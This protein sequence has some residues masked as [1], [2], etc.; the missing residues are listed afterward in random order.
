MTDL[1]EVFTIRHEPMPDAWGKY[2]R[3]ARVLVLSDEITTSERRCEVARGLLKGKWR[4][5]GSPV[6]SA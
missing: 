6:E 5:V 2:Y 4:P 3:N 1:A